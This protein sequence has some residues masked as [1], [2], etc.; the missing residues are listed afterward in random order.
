MLSAS[1]GVACG[2]RVPGPAPAQTGHASA[3]ARYA[4]G[5]AARCCRA[6]SAAVRT[7]AISWSE[8]GLVM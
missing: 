8:I 5:G 6:V 7:R 3:R 2:V 4:A 1:G